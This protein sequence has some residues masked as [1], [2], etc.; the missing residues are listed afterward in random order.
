VRGT[1]RVLEIAAADAPGGRRQAWEY[2]PGVPDPDRLPVVYFLHGLPG[3]WSDLPR[4]GAKEALDRIFASGVAPFILV[5]PDGASNGPR[6]T[7]WADSSDGRVHL[8]G[9]VTGPLIA[10]V[11]GAHR[12]PRAERAIVGFSMG[13]YGAAMVAFRHGDLYGQLGV[14]AGYFKIDD[15]DGVFAGTQAEHDPNEHVE[16]FRGLRV[17]LVEDAGEKLALVRGEA[18]R[19]GEALQR[20][21]V[22]ASVAVTPG[23]HSPAWVVAQL[24]ALARFLNAGFAQK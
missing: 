1:T 10:A 3:S 6:D 18:A 14:L 21:G 12:R 8:E 24:P 7:E 16:A 20:A 13:G 4:A 11:E 23:S 2:V 22:D 5:A 19:F 9:F 15:P 17:L